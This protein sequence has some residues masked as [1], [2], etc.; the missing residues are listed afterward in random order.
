[1]QRVSASTEIHV[2]YFNRVVRGHPTLDDVMLC[3]TAPLYLLTYLLTY[4]SI[5]GLGYGMLTAFYLFNPFTADP[6][7]AL[8]FAILV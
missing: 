2:F 1:M 6:V 4:Y 7:K 5:V 8:Y 3:V